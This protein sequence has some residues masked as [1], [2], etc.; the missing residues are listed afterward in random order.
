MN[1]FQK[2]IECDIWSYPSFLRFDN[3]ESTLKLT[4]AAFLFFLH[5]KNIAMVKL[6]NKAENDDILHRYTNVRTLYVSINTYK[7]RAYKLRINTYILSVYMCRICYVSHTY[8]KYLRR[9]Y[10][11]LCIPLRILVWR[12]LS[13]EIRATPMHFKIRKNMLHLPVRIWLWALWIQDFT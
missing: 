6:H 12:Y 9:I 11:W 10:E 1:N 13:T 2:H 5:W 3:L 7:Y 4:F 8:P